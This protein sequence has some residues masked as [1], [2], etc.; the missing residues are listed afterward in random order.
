MSIMTQ[1]I[2]P[3]GRASH[4]RYPAIR[5]TLAA[6]FWRCIWLRPKIVAWR[7]QKLESLM[8][9][10]RM[11]TT[12]QNPFSLIGTPPLFFVPNLDKAKRGH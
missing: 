9:A 6:A 1:R 11:L 4:R 12:L 5:I 8:N 7:A 10:C 3:H 2:V